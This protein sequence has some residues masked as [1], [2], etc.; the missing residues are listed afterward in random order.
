[1]ISFR[2]KEL[3]YF[4]NNFLKY[5]GINVP[6]HDEYDKLCFYF[7]AFLFCAVASSEFNGEGT[8]RAF[9]K[10]DAFSYIKSLR[11][12]SAH[13][14]APH[15]INNGKGSL[16]FTRQIHSSIGTNDNKIELKI[17]IESSIEEIRKIHDQ[18]KIA[19]PGKTNGNY[20]SSVKYLESLNGQTILIH[21]LFTAVLASISDIA[22]LH[23]LTQ[24]NLLLP[25]ENVQS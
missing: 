2:A 18:F 5:S 3:K 10:I 25:P 1:M 24:E 21:D 8:K 9:Y 20:D 12:I 11:N 19:N 15:I 7:D 4:Y 17:N 23:R 16:F 22:A 14:G 6:Q 13:Y